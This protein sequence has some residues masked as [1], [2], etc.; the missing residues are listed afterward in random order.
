M[1]KRIAGD[2]VI[3]RERRDEDAEFFARWYNDSGVMF[4]CAFTEPTT[5]EKEL[6]TIRR[7]APDSDWYAITDKAG[8]IVGET[9]LLRMWIPWRCCD[10]SIIIP[11]PADQGKGYGKDAIRLMIDLAFRRYGMNRVSI[12]V[13][14][15][16][17]YALDFYKSVGFKQEGVQEQ[18]YCYNGEYSDFVMMR[19]LR[20]EYETACRF[21]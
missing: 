11:D 12:G 14:G 2:K 4:K 7:K 1:E 20:S 18:G 8:S 6:A 21:T 13:V 15:L 5:V 10:L 16:N 19:L 17:R 9:G 3:L